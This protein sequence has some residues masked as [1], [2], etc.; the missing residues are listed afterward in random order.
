MLSSSNSSFGRKRDFEGI[1]REAKN[2]ENASVM[3]FNTSV[4]EKLF[5]PQSS[6]INNLSNH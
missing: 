1:R 6:F 5:E 3:S 2:S 4:S